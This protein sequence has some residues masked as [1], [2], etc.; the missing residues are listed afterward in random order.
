MGFN[1]LLSGHTVSESQEKGREEFRKKSSMGREEVMSACTEP[2]LGPSTGR[3]GML[4]PQQILLGAGIMALS[5][6]FP[7]IAVELSDA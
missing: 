7:T 6:A 1:Y 5:R 2:P 4:T 3:A